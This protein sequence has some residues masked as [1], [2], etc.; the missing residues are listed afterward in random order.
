MPRLLRLALAALAAALAAAESP[1]AAQPAITDGAS[2]TISFGER[3]LGSTG[4]TL[5]SRA[6]SITD[7]TSNTILLR[8]GASSCRLPIAAP[9]CLVSTQPPAGISDG[10]SNTIYVGEAPGAA[11][12]TPI[13]A[14]CAVQTLPGLVTD[15][16]SNT[17]LIGEIVAP[18]G[19][20]RS[21]ALPVS[22]AGCTIGGAGGAT[23]GTTNTILFGALLDGCVLPV[24]GTG[25]L[26]DVRLQPDGGICSGTPGGIVDGTS[27]T[28]LISE[29]A[30]N[31]PG[32]VV[33]PE[34]ATLA[35]LAAGLALVG[36][37]ARRR[38]RGSTPA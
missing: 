24:A 21:C 15:G 34:P 1:A 20:G 22:G 3:P 27:N 7:G 29:C 33:T 31:A 28:I 35:L 10:T 11:C 38:A 36:A 26:P 37:G 12:V 13:G 8:G 9:T 23:D 18:G 6:G 4:C 25:G 16:T 19:G 32:V 5:V 14:R 17:L 30:A 2:N